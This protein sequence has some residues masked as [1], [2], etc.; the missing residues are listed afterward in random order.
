MI[1]RTWFPFLPLFFGILTLLFVRPHSRI[2]IISKISKRRVTPKCQDSRGVRSW[3]SRISLSSDADD[4]KQGIRVSQD[5]EEEAATS[6]RLRTP[7]RRGPAFFLSALWSTSK[8]KHAGTRCRR[9]N[10]GFAFTHLAYRPSRARASVTS[11][12][13]FPQ[14]R[15]RRRSATVAGRRRRARG[16]W[17][18][19]LAVLKTRAL[20]RHETPSYPPRFTTFPA[21]IRKP[22]NWPACLPVEPARSAPRTAAVARLPVSVWCRRGYTI[23]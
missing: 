5:S 10:V 17:Y 3:W 7:C 9:R 2:L 22:P 6:G 13:L 14:R 1:S 15:R 16:S 23:R 8:R 19:R 18:R 20:N 12:V 11:R 4:Q 21:V